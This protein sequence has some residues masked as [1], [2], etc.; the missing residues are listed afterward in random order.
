[1]TRIRTEAVTNEYEIRHARPEPDEVPLDDQR[2]SQSGARERSRRDWL[3]IVKGAGRKTIADNM[4]MIARALAFS[5]FLAIPAV[6]LVALGLFTLLAG[7]Q[8]IGN[9]MH[10]FGSVMPQ[11]ATQLLG[12]SLA[13]LSSQHSAGL[14]MTIVGFLEVVP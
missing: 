9:L 1:M 5:T 4:P 10:H 2:R 3:A 6:L 7:P 13:R 11:Q 12:K 8:T 14:A